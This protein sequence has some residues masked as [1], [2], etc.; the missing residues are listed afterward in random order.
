MGCRFAISRSWLNDAATTADYE[1][2]QAAGITTQLPTMP[3]MSFSGPDATPPRRR[4]EWPSLVGTQGWTG[5]LS[6][7]VPALARPL[8]TASSAKAPGPVNANSRKP[9]Q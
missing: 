6:A 3:G 5:R 4:T 1:R 9:K 2:A 7:G 8:I